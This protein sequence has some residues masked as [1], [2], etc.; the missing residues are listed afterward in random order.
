MSEV[1]DD[2]AAS[3]STTSVVTVGGAAAAGE[4]EIGDDQDWFEVTLAADERY[5][6]LARGAS[7]GN[8]TL[9]APDE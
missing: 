2:F 9:E 7:T 3:T 6:F 1:T 4:M 8:G 5:W